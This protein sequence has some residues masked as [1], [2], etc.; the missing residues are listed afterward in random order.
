[1]TKTAQDFSPGAPKIKKPR[2]ARFFYFGWRIAGSNRSPQTC[3][4]CA[5]PDELI[6]HVIFPFGIAKIYYFR[7][8]QIFYTKSLK[9]PSTVSFNSFSNKGLRNNLM[10]SGLALVRVISP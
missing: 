6:P 3:H 4:A 10:T 5:L 2:I 9:I 1:M 8:L 7:E